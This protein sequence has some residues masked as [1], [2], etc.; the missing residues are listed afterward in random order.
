MMQPLSISQLYERYKQLH[1]QLE[2]REIAHPQFVNL[3]QQ[4]QAQDQIGKWWT[5]DPQTGQ[6]LPYTA[7]GWISA[8]PPAARPSSPQ[9]KPAAGRSAP[10]A[11]PAKVKSG[12]GWRGCL[13]SPLVVGILSFSTAD[14]LA[15][16]TVSTIFQD[17][18]DRLW[19]GN[20][21]NTEGGVSMFDGI[22]WTTLSVKDGLAH[23]MLNAMWEDADNTLW[24][25]AGF[26]S[27]G[28]LSMWDGDVWQTLTQDDGLAGAKVR[29]LYRDAAGVMWVGSEYNGITRLSD[30][31]WQV[32]TPQ[33]GMAG[34][35]VKAMLQDSQGN[36]WLGAEGG[37]P[38]LSHEAWLALPDN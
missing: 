19:F 22:S 31:G 26:S 28:G 8:T 5:I 32:F 33:E 1:G 21:Y 20:G 35:E 10:R 17:S 9:P 13:S 12:G 24:F 2:R 14:G 11:A 7:T 15:S 3:V 6:Y 25:G 30:G 36:L 27:F 34:W 37:L 4:L 23:H 16:N 29:Y 38:R 18:Q